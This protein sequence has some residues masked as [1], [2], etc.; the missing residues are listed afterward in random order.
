MFELDIIRVCTYIKV[1]HFQHNLHSY[2][3]LIFNHA[4]FLS[5]H[6]SQSFSPQPL[7]ILF[8]TTPSKIMVNKFSDK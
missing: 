1:L 6:S 5:N 3:C 7:E 8:S 2:E 4:I